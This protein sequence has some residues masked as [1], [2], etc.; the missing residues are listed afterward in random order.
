MSNPGR[1]KAVVHKLVFEL[2]YEYGFEY[3]DRAGATI[4][5]ILRDSPGWVQDSINP[6]QGILRHVDN[7]ATFSFNAQKLYLSQQQS[8]KIAEV[9]PIED[10][11]KTAERL[12][13][14]VRRQLQ[15]GV[16]EQ[17]FTR[18]GFRV[19]H[20]FEQRSLEDAKQSIKNLGF[21]SNDRFTTL[22]DV[23]S[24]DEISLSAVV[25]RPTCRTRIA[26]AAVEQNI[27]LD[28]ATRKEA[29]QTPHAF[30]TGQKERLVEKIKAKRR[31]QRYPQF[32]VLIDM[33]HSIEDP[34][35]PAHLN[36]ASDFIVPNYEWG[37]KAAVALVHGAAKGA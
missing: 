20:L 19:W 31:V 30:P 11:A 22:A 10:F 29:L 14:I 13:D 16:T 27:A 24:V 1:A 32:A 35:Y 36:I 3:F 12:T 28:P 5:E 25:D 7:E 9:M 34:V 15:L 17:D 2:R 8:E 26:I 21:V 18:I 37:E 6:Q 4:N 33:D 23:Q